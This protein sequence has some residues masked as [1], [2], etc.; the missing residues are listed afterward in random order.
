MG[1]G[2]IR[3]P[4]PFPRVADPVP[5]VEKVIELAQQIV[6]PRGAGKTH[7]GLVV[8]SIVVS[9]LN[10]AELHVRAAFTTGK[11]TGGIQGTDARDRCLSRCIH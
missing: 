9:M 4:R 5:K 11:L 2:G 6:V 7:A 1:I 8:F 3:D 10:I